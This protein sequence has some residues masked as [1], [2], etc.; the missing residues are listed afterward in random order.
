MGIPLVPNPVC[1][2]Q[3]SWYSFSLSGRGLGLWCLVPITGY[4]VAN[5]WGFRQGWSHGTG[6][7]IEGDDTQVLSSVMSLK[8]SASPCEPKDHSQWLGN[9]MTQP[10]ACTGP[11]VN[12]NGGCGGRGRAQVL[13]LSAFGAWC[14]RKREWRLERQT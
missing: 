13:K 14:G 2:T 6:F 1:D 8:G 12:M 7:W 5:T 3:V 4:K 10:R 11:C 9:R